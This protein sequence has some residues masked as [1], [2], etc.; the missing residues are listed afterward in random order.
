MQ[1][2]FPN[3]GDLWAQN[4]EHSILNGD[5]VSNVLYFAVVTFCAPIWEEVGIQSCVGIVSATQQ[6]KQ[7]QR[8]TPVQSSLQFRLVI[9]LILCT[10]HQCQAFVMT[11]S[12]FAS[13]N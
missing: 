9:S 6:S 3:D 7:V 5:P 12:K 11:K 13:N 2:W 10:S 8:I 4:L 1:I